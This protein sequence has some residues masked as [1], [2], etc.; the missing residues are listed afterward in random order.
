MLAA[1]VWLA[2]SGFVIASV[3]ASASGAFAAQAPAADG[4]AATGA[5][6]GVVDG[7]VTTATADPEKDDAPRVPFRGS[8]LFWDNA[9]SIDTL[10]VG[11]DYQS[12]NPVYEMAFGFRPRYYFRDVDA[13][14][15]SVRGDIALLRE[16]TD[17]DSTTER[18]EWTF[19]DA[20]VWLA[21]VRRVNDSPGATTDVILRAPQLI[22]PTSKV[23]ASNGKILGLGVGAGVEQQVPLRGDGASF[24][25][26]AALRVNARY[27]YQ[28]V[29]STVPTNDDFD[30]V[31]LGPDGRSLPSDQ[32]SGSAFTQHQ[33][34]IS[35]QSDLS[36]VRDLTL[37]TEFGMRYA[38]RRALDERVEVC[39]VVATG[40]AEVETREDGS[41]YGVS[42]LFNVELGYDL[43]K[44]LSLA[45]G[46][47]NLTPQLGADGQRRQPFYSHDARGYLTV[48]L[49]LDE[50]YLAARGERTTADAGLTHQY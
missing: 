48:T 5:E 28:F 21:Y 46:Y 36:L 8:T 37:S 2:R 38:Y 19:T 47:S 44:Q 15:L 33:G 3:S 27:V 31:R 41:R 20:E 49:A 26:K 12:G 45:I 50:L 13:E 42:T 25:P 1:R 11:Q 4:A 39:G 43:T 7:G 32:L 35:V 24:L 9:A 16:F 18:G 17:S 30:R 10:G 6:A 22:L 40:C 14:S 23:S 29:S 34:A